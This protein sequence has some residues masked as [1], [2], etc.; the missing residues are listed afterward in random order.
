MRDTVT[1][2]CCRDRGFESDL[3]K[4]IVPPNQLPSDDPEVLTFDNGRS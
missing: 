4:E 2:P 1:W 3:R